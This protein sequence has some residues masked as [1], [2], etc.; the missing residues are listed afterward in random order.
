MNN[1]LTSI[2]VQLMPLI[3]VVSAVAYY[4]L[5]NAVMSGVSFFFAIIFFLVLFSEKY[6]N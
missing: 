6:K 3:L 4:Y 5:G 2:G 1:K